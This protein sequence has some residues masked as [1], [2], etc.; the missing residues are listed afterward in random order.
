METAPGGVAV[1]ALALAGLIF[2]ADLWR[3][4]IKH[5]RLSREERR[6]E[7][8]RQPMIRL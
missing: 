4:A 6:W 2:A 7:R 8:E 5:L 3:E 1:F